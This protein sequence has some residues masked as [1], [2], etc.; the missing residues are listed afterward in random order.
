MKKIILILSFIC[1]CVFVYSQGLTSSQLQLKADIFTF[2]KEERMAPVDN[3]NGVISFT[4]DGTKY[5]IVISDTD[6][7]PM[8]V[9]FSVSYSYSKEDYD[10]F[11]VLLSANRMNWYKGVKFFCDEESI[12]FQAEMYL[13]ESEPFR[14]AFY[15]LMELMNAM[16]NDFPEVYKE[17]MESLGSNDEQVEQEKQEE[18]SSNAVIVSFPTI[19]NKSDSKLYLTKVTLDDKFTALDFTSYNS[20][21]TTSY[22]WCNISRETAITVGGKSYKITDAKG[23]KFSPEYTY[24]PNSNSSISFQLIFP[25]IPKNTTR[26]DFSEGTEGWTMTGIQLSSKPKPS[27]KVGNVISVNSTKIETQLHSW[28]VISVELLDDCTIV[29]KRVTPKTT[30]TYVY[31]EPEEYIEDSST[32]KK[33]FLKSSSIGFAS[34]R[35]V[36]HSSSPYEFTETYPA[37]PMSVRT[38]NISSGSKYYVMN[39][40]CRN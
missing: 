27:N 14:Y 22:E 12:M 36:L 1:S 37:L 39:L 35:T 2:L 5:A 34:N 38:I 26:I 20:N 28:T 25:P 15:R 6:V 40:R 31:S 17:T 4:K 8:Y 9:T 21:G 11:G 33:Y 10:Y 16:H 29:R 3:E 19:D 30:E 24:Y 18:P 7:T 23:I 32:G 13:H